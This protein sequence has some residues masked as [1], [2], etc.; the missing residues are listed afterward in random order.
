MTKCVFFAVYWQRQEEGKITK[1]LTT[2]ARTIQITEKSTQSCL[3]DFQNPT[4][5]LSED[6]Y[7]LKRQYRIVRLDVPSEGKGQRT[8]R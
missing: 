6:T 4:T 5:C 8:G 7:T 1:D 2:M 3:T